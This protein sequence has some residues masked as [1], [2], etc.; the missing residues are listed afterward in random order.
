LGAG[1][2]HKK[3]A[4][5]HFITTL[6]ANLVFTTYAEP[7]QLKQGIIPT[8]PVDWNRQFEEQIE[9]QLASHFDYY[10]L[11]LCHL[12]IK[13]S[14][15]YRKVCQD[16]LDKFQASNETDARQLTGW[17]CAL[18]PD[19]LTDYSRAIDLLQ[20][21]QELATSPS[22]HLGTLL[23]RSG[24][25]EKARDQL[26]R[27]TEAVDAKFTSVYVWYFL[28]MAEFQLGNREKAQE[29][30]KKASS[31]TTGL[32][33]AEQAGKKR[34]AWNHRATLRLLDAEANALILEH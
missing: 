33:A 32:I 22:Y 23:Y 15:A 11:A 2:H 27:F 16:M 31:F 19:A 26:L 3:T 29:W 24:E 21:A 1:P 20:R 18:A 12:V 6:N 28:S 9:N 14:T 4:L 8:F 17:A 10:Q 13:D 34:V 30:L 5:D 7:I 25:F